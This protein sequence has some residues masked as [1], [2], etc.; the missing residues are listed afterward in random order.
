MPLAGL[1]AAVG[2]ALAGRAG[3]RLAGAVRRCR[4]PPTCSALVMALPG[5]RRARVLGIDDFALRKGT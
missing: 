3:A 1:L 4:S 5:G 2:A